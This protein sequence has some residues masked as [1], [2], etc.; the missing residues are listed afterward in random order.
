[1]GK[2]SNQ[3]NRG[4]GIASYGVIL[5]WLL[6]SFL[7]AAGVAYL[8][9]RPFILRARNHPAKQSQRL[10]LPGAQQGRVS[11]VF[12]ASYLGSGLELGLGSGPGPDLQLDLELDRG[13]EPATAMGPGR[14][15]D[16]AQVQGPRQGDGDG[17]R[18]A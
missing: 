1:M 9:I 14:R 16:H 8:L 10:V 17:G 6:I 18:S 2:N 12:E 3:E 11:A 4:D 15:S 13:R 5:A 7:L